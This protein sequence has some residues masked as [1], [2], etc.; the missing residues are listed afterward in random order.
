LREEFKEPPFSVIDART[1]HWHER[2]R[3]WKALGLRSDIGRDGTEANIVQN[4]LTGDSYCRS[5]TYGEVSIFDPSLCEVLY[6]WFCPPRAA[7]LDPFAGGSVR[8]I[9]AH[10]LGHTYTG[11]D[12]RREQVESNEEQGREI[13]A[14]DNQ[15]R[16]LC[17]DSDALLPTLPPPPGKPAGFDFILSCPP[18][19]NL[20]V[21]SDLPG[22]ISNMEYGDFLPVYERII[23]KSCALLA[24][25]ALACFVVGEVRD[26]HGHYIGFVPDTIRAFQKCGMHFY[27]DAILLNV[28]GT[29][30]LRAASNMRTQKLV[31]VHQNVLVFKKP[32]AGVAPWDVAGAAFEADRRRALQNRTARGDSDDWW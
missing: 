15:P 6:H 22:D 8:G 32:E 31:K 13:L 10:A 4:N 14:P 1:G 27:N 2:K 28:A 21:Y 29:A 20:E 9:I 16:W 3:A 17:G 11:I 18:Y 26:K 19:F 23:R 12:I 25:G 7:I 5:Y 24:P 30:P